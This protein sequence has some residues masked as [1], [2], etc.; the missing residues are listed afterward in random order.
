MS[1]KKNI[2]IQL[3]KIFDRFKPFIDERMINE[4][5]NSYKERYKTLNKGKEP[6]K[7]DINNLLQMIIANDNCKW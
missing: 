2:L 4:F 6:S 7:N 5:I 3:T 1:Y